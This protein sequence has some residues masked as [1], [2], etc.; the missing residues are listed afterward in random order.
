[1][2]F[3]LS[4]LLCVSIRQCD[5]V[6]GDISQKLNVMPDLMFDSVNVQN[7]ALGVHIGCNF[8]KIFVHIKR[9]SL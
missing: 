2:L 8:I 3:R 7:S 5:T 1:L 4:R 6:G 9:R